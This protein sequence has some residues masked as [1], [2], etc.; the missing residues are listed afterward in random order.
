MPYLKYGNLFFVRCRALRKAS[1]TLLRDGYFGPGAPHP[2]LHKRIGDYT[3]LMRDSYV[4][5]DWVPG[6]R[7]H[8]L[9][10]VHGGL[11]VSE[12][13]VPLCIAQT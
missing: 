12:M 7:P 13:T 3:L 1:E 6:E 9:I 11:S 4:L 5:K 8:T 10:G 2:R